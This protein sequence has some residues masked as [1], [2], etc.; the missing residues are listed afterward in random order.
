MSCMKDFPGLFNIPVSSDDRVHLSPQY[1]TKSQRLRTVTVQLLA[2][3]VI[4]D[5]LHGVYQQQQSL[6][7]C[8]RIH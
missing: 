3:I 5:R 1:T 8:G 7:E 6:Y 4:P 2:I